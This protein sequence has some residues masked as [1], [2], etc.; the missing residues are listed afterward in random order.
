[1]SGLLREEREKVVEQEK[2]EL[3]QLKAAGHRLAVTR[4]GAL[5]TTRY[6]EHPDI[7]SI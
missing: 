3:A 2:R 4:S 1:M 5:M 6:Y 7:V